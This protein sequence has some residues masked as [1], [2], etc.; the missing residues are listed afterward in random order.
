[1]AH[2]DEHRVLSDKQHAFRRW[3]SCET[4]LVTVID[5]AKTLAN[6]RQV[7]TF[8][9]DYEKKPLTTFLMNFLQANCLAAMEL[10]EKQ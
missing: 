3:H 1:M 2:L 7:D 9:L 8:I 4:Q 10:E 5:W 6:K